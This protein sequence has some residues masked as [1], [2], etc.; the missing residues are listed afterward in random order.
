VGV[1]R[2][3]VFVS[4]SL[5]KKAPTPYWNN[6]TFLNAFYHLLM[7]QANKKRQRPVLKI[8]VI[9]PFF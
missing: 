8:K 3:G 1:G 4:Y 7:S 6:E 2:G 9:M 5:N